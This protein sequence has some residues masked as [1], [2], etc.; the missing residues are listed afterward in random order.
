MLFAITGGTLTELLKVP[1][2]NLITSFAFS[3]N[4]T[5][6]AVGDE[7]GVR[8]LDLVWPDYAYLRTRVC[9]LVWRNL[10]RSEWHN[11]PPRPPEP[12]RLSGVS[13]GPQTSGPVSIL[14]R[15][16]GCS[17]R[18]RCPRRTTRLDEKTSGTGSG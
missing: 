18:G 15:P 3:P 13:V 1:D 7:V 9:G 5:E 11:R 6:L 17:Q 14:S 16:L 10:S 4:G 2:G 8:L 12:D